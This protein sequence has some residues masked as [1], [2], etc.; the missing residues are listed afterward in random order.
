MPWVKKIA[1]DWV[2]SEK[3]DLKVGDKFFTTDVERLV[4]EGKAILI[5]ENGNELSRG[6]TTRCPVCSFTTVDA[7]ELANHILS[8][9]QKKAEKPVVEEKKE[10]PVVSSVITEAK[11]IVKKAYKDMTPEEQKQFRIDNLKKAREAR[12]NA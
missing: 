9:H 4:A 2:P 11:E 5:D 3:K 6:V 1:D 7:I 12:K 8:E 10:T